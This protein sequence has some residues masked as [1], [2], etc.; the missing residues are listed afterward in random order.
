MAREPCGAAFR[1]VSQWVISA[2]SRRMTRG[3]APAT[4]MASKRSS[5]AAISPFMRCSKR[6]NIWTC[7]ATP[8]MSRTS[9]S[10]IS[11]SGPGMGDGLIEQRQPVADRS[12]GG[13]GDEGN[14]A[15]RDADILLFGDPGEMI[16]QHVEI[17]APQVEALA[18]GQ[19]RDRNLPYLRRRED[20]LHVLRRLLEGLEQRVERAGR[21][22]VHFVDDV[23]LVAAGR[24]AVEHAL[25]K[26][27]HL[28]DA[29]VAG[30]VDLD[31]VDVAVLRDRHALVAHAARLRGRPALAVRPDAV[32]HARDDA[33]RRRLADA[34]HAGQHERVGE[35]SGVD[36][37]R[38]RAHHRVLADQRGEV[39]G[40]V[41][42][43]ENA[44]GPDVCV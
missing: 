19:H 31:D 25:E 28:R 6:S 15:R 4:Y 9:C 30:R 8:S 23:D 43:G 26:L 7:S 12:V 42:A 37:V 13:A 11:E 34:A 44:V 10:P 33:R 38:K 40:S 1:R 41:L 3:S 22:H 18:S 36:R 20:E 24:G 17:H 14:R 2:R 27:A 29:G 5:A 21:E 35:A 39:A 32:E 16:R